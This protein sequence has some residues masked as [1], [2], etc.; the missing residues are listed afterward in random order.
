VVRQSIWLQCPFH[1]EDQ[2]MTSLSLSPPALRLLRLPGEFGPILRCSGELS[3]ATAESLRRE[4]ALLTS[5]GHSALTLNL[6]DCTFLD[7]DGILT[8]L[9]A[10][11]ALRQKG[12]RLIL[13]AGRG[14]IAR[15]LQFM[16]IERFL[17]IFPTEETAVA[18]IR[19]GGL[20][21]PGPATWEAARA[22]TVVR[23][24]SVLARLDEE[25]PE[26]VMRQLTGM[27]ALCER[28]EDLFQERSTPVS[29]RCHFCP[30]FH[31]LGG[32][33]RDVGCRSVLDPMIDAVR[34]GDK[35]RT[36]AQIEELIR[37]VEEMPLPEKMAYPTPWLPSAL[38]DPAV[39]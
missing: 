30:L 13:V 16:G 7:V 1:Q 39:E 37:T 38:G 9:H 8:F 14:R 33:E 22:E 17:P 32:Q 15:L 34:E 20:P 12:S 23:W 26:E 11:K 25:P 19:G 24:R 18:A 35:D 6:A 27:T 10:Y 5:M 4:L 21:E 36:K 3:V 28:S 29:A 31:E 2:P